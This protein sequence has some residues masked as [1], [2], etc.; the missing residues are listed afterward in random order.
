MD[1][2]A[3][4]II[5]QLIRSKA[6]ICLPDFDTGSTLT[7]MT[8]CKFRFSAPPAMATHAE[9]NVTCHTNVKQTAKPG[10]RENMREHF[11]IAGSSEVDESVCGGKSIYRSFTHCM[12]TM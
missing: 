10:T 8:E 3:S 11:L 1:S 4:D 6:D 7:Q 9:K 2:L 5:K 12:V